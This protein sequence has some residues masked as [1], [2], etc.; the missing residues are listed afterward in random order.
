MCRKKWRQNPGKHSNTNHRLSLL[1]GDVVSVDQ[2]VSSTPGLVACLY[3]GRP[4]TEHYLGSTVFVDHASDFSY[5]YHHT[6]LISTQTVHAKQAF[7]TEAQQ[8]GVIIKHC[9]ADNG[10]FCTKQFLQD[11]TKKGQTISLAGVGA[12]HQKGI[13]EKRIGDLQ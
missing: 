7:E 1:P 2:L 3:G 8:H 6:A 11:L 5:I 9:H 4:T 12:H 10:L 13:A